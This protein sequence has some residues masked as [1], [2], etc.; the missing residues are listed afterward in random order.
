MLAKHCTS[1]SLA[2]TVGALEGL[3]GVSPGLLLLG[4]GGWDLEGNP[5]NTQH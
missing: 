3:G 2:D 4:G 1:T 5:H